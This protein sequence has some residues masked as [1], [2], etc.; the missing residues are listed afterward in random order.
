MPESVGITLK[1]DLSV[2]NESSTPF[3]NRLMHLC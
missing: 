1:I 2:A 3:E